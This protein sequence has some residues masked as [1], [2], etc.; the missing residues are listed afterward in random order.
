M[1]REKKDETRKMKF[2]KT[3]RVPFPIMVPRSLHYAARRAERQRARESGR[4]G[5][6][7]IC[8]SAQLDE[9]KKRDGNTEF[10]EIGIQRAQRQGEEA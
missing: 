1:R 5:R 3:N 4:S 9:Q 8:E 2:K 7:D 10:T 6:D